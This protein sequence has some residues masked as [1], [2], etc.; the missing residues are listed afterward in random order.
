MPAGR[1]VAVIGGGWAGLAAA[2]EATRRGDRV[3]LFEMAPQ[4]GGR[5]REVVVEGLALDNGQHICIGAYR[6]TLGLLREIGIAEADVFMRTPLRL[7]GADGAGL[8]LR[9]GPPMLAFAAAVLRHPTWRWREKIALLGAAGGWLTS[10]FRCDP[11]L[12]VARLTIDLPPVVR[13]ELIEPLCVAALNTAADAASARVFLRVL[14]DAL[15][16]GRG[17]ADLLLPRVSLSETLPAPA[18]RWLDGAHAAIRLRHRVDSLAADGD[19]WRV[20]GERFEAAVLAAAPPE[21]ARLARPI[22]PAWADATMEL[23]YEPIV[24]VYMRSPAT[25]LPEPMLA[26]RGDAANPAQF[27]FDRGQLGGPAGLLAFVASGAGAWV[28]AGAASTLAATRRQAE[29]ALGR[30]LRAPLEAVQVVTERRATFRCTPDL[31][32][33]GL[34]IARRLCAAGDHV[35]GPYPSTLEGAVRSGLAAARALWQ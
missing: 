7:M 9:G 18:A 31:H 26:L 14:G 11:L 35:D 22:A 4:L 6:E 5:A 23:Q 20:D 33:P 17:S 34:N 24:T 1:A 19:A 2:I 3:T 25:V 30:W 12:T 16:G 28:E 15:F 27:V 32:R 21:S 13:A 29:S 10:G 8:A